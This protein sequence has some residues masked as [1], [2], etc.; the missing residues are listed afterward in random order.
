MSRHKGRQNDRMTPEEQAARL[1]F[2]SDQLALATPFSGP[3][4]PFVGGMAT[5]LTICSGVLASQVEDEVGQTHAATSLLAE[6]AG[7]LVMRKLKAPLEMSE[8]AAAAAAGALD[9]PRALMGI[10]THIV[11]SEEGNAQGC[12]CD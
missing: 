8:A 6:R 9:V 11:N 10:S 2:F 3:A 7:S 1:G 5:F 12:S 4:A